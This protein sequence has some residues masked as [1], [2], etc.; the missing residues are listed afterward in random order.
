MVTYILGKKFTNL[1]F[2]NIYRTQVAKHQ[3]EKN[4]V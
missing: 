3:K 1:T 2:Q 4:P